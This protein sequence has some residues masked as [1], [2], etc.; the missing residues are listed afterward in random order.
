M[1]QF[2]NE[3]SKFYP[4]AE[5]WIPKYADDGIEESFEVPSRRLLRSPL[6]GASRKSS[7]LYFLVDEIV[8]R[9]FARLS[10]IHNLRRVC[11][12]LK[13]FIFKIYIYNVTREIRKYAKQFSEVVV[14]FP[15]A[16]TMAILLS[17]MLLKEAFPNVSIRLRTFSG[18]SRGPFASGNEL[19]DLANLVKAGKP[20]DFK[21]GFEVEPYEKILL[22]AGFASKD[23]F[24]A[25]IPSSNIQPW[26]T[27]KFGGAISLGFLGG[28]KQRK[29]FETI[30]QLLS[31][32]TTSG[33]SFKSF[34]QEAPFPWPEYAKAIQALDALCADIRYVN[35]KLSSEEL[36]LAILGCDLL[37]LPYDPESYRLSGSG[38]LFQAADLGVPVLTTE[39]T[40][41]SK[42]I[43]EHGIGGVYES[44]EEFTSFISAFSL[45]T[46]RKNL[47]A[48]N[49][50]R[51]DA[52]YE[53]LTLRKS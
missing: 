45:E 40:G 19:F 12:Y 24:W 18:E 2:S 41:F 52:S 17:K 43:T 16:D 11:G 36:Q 7:P 53:F 34:I 14:F 13:R 6:Y 26:T 46:F 27:S 29:G 21:I 37:V 51:N 1:Q 42:E 20:D 28:A 5:L 35:P 15:S 33:I 47:N 9:G 30:P 48:Y 4:N 22:K 10:K 3:I 39:G 44:E 38:L 23:I 50:K 25:P 31:S 32:L 49:R 8:N